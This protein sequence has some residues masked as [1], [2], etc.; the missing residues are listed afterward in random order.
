MLSLAQT[1][2]KSKVWNAW[3]AYLNT[4]RQKTRKKEIAEE[5]AKSC[6]RR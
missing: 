1:Y 6:R 4:K 5:F 3:R 2:Q